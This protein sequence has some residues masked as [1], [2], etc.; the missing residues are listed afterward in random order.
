MNGLR[1]TLLAILFALPVFLSSIEAQEPFALGSLL[2]GVRESF[3]LILAAEEERSI[4]QGTRLGA[5]GEFDVR[6]KTRCK[7][8]L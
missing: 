2:Q 5:L 8:G 6:W 7:R 4:A 1:S 3:P